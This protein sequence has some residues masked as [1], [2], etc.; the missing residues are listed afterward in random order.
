MVVSTSKNIIY[1]DGDESNPGN[2]MNRIQTMRPKFD[3]Q[4]EFCLNEEGNGHY[5][6]YLASK[7]SCDD[8]SMNVP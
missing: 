5:V 1:V 7:S 2:D 3:D 8:F 4:L 6:E